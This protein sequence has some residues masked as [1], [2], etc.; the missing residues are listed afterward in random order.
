MSVK[1][2]NTNSTN[3][4]EVQLTYD[5][6]SGMP[7][8]PDV[9]DGIL[10]NRLLTAEDITAIPDTFPSF[11]CSVLLYYKSSHHSKKY[12]SHHSQK[13]MRS[14]VIIKGRYIFLTK[15]ISDQ[16]PLR[17]IP[18]EQITFLTSDRHKRK[19]PTRNKNNNSE[20]NN[21]E[22]RFSEFEIRINGK[23]S[24]SHENDSD[25]RTFFQLV[26]VICVV[27]FFILI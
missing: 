23:R 9:V 25:V 19:S 2:E 13:W 7:V 24:V 14:Y 22:N 3:S 10:V 15:C 5:R 16:T 21:S 11:S 17:I 6:H 12:L 1:S 8:F 26:G 20:N 27:L 18:L 4:T